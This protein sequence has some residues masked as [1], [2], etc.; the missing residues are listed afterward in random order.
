MTSFQ[1]PGRGF[2]AIQ[3]GL[4]F[5]FFFADVEHHLKKN[6]NVFVGNDIPVG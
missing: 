4:F 1:L 6:E 2:L 3:P 5:A